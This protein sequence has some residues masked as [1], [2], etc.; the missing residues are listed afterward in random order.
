MT[1]T[2]THMC[3]WERLQLQRCP[4]S[5]HTSLHT[6][7]HV[8]V[9]SMWHQPPSYI[10]DRPG[11]YPAQW[12]G[13]LLLGHIGAQKRLLL[14]QNGCH[15]SSFVVFGGVVSV[16]SVKLLVGNANLTREP[17]H[18]SQTWQPDPICSAPQQ[19]IPAYCGCFLQVC[20]LQYAHNWVWSLHK[21]VRAQGYTSDICADDLDIAAAPTFHNMLEE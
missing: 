7:T 12:G 11:S 13:A 6:I 21:K 4:G 9:R 15:G 3:K 5:Y 18:Q 14:S 20:T 2:N 8:S 19:S 17:H 1:S 16:D 10:P